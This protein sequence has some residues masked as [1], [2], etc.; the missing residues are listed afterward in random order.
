M[1]LTNQAPIDSASSSSGRP[2]RIPPS[3]LPGDLRSLPA[4]LIKMGLLAAVV[5]LAVYALPQLYS[6]HL[7]LGFAAVALSAVL[8]LWVYLTSKRI[9]RKYLVPGTLLLI[10]FQIYP[11][12]YLLQISF[13]NYG[14][15]HFLT[16]QQ[17]VAAITQDSFQPVPGAAAY[18]LGVATKGDPADPSTGFVFFLTGP[19]GKVYLGTPAG[20][21]PF[22]SH[23]VTMSP[24]GSVLSAPGWKFL[25]P[26][27]VN[28]L[29]A[30]LASYSVPAGHG[31]FIR[32]E[33]VSGAYVGRATM[34]FNSR[35]GD[36]VDLT[37]REKFAPQTG[38]FVATNGSGDTLTAGWRAG[39]GFSNYTRVFTDPTIRGPFV[40]IL[41]WTF[42]FAV[43]S[44]VSTFTL[45]LFLAIVLNHPRLRGKA[46]YRTGLLFPWAVPSFITIIVW[47]SMFNPR[48]GLI[49]N[50]LHINVNWFGSEWYA[51]AMLLVTNLWLG[52]PYM[53]LISLGVL[54][55]IPGDVMEAAKVDGA[56]GY[57]AFRN[58]IFPLLLLTVEP[59]L[60]TSFAFNFNNFNMIQLMTNGAPFTYGSAT[61]GS[62]DLV[63]SYT[64]RLAFGG[65]GRQ[66]GFAAA[67]SVLL[68][69]L[70][71]VMALV[72]LRR[73]QS[74]RTLK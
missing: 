46:I 37:T 59:L 6:K 30:R 49:N 27:E 42:S 66:Y 62:T 58:V 40:K 68:F 16:E 72:G 1:G 32:S 48:F 23:G 34:Q 24:T 13:S 8:I 25:S 12:A 15:G 28:N 41:V 73:T 7:W 63:I 60:I 43:I 19:T 61:A 64:Y 54:Q 31:E 71:A 52:F 18:S 51:K 9:E 67:L 17:A 36:F 50:M 47:F 53:F 38:T 65:S 74:F 44:V 70:V 57:Q 29:G 10:F 11:I 26:V 56:T 20:L 45:G 69:L 2:G 33:G 21:V 3:L 5:G 22:P 14:D 4:Y 55:S 39:V 35:T